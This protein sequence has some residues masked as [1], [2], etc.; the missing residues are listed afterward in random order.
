MVAKPSNAEKIRR[1][2]IENAQLRKALF[3][4]T[5]RLTMTDEQ[6]LAALLRTRTFRW[7][8]GLRKL[9]GK[10]LRAYSAFRS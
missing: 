6:H 7:T 1:L 5:S 3:G 2:E 10:I 8:S 4:D 9:W